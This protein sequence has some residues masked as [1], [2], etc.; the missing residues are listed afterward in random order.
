MYEQHT[1]WRKK[2]EYSPDDI[3]RHLGSGLEDATEVE[4][5]QVMAAN[6]EDIAKWC[7]G[8]PIEERN[9]FDPNNIMFGINLETPLGMK[10]ATIGDMVVKQDNLFH[11]V[12]P[13]QFE[14]LFEPITD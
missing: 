8:T 11:V 13:G 9:P 12:P 2:E 5:V 6:G 1:R 14:G 4:A 10:R 7:G 3:L